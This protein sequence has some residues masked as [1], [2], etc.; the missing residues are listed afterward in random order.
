MQFPLCVCA[1]TVKSEA[2][3]L[4]AYSFNTDLSAI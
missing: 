1:I 3:I 4:G 2:F